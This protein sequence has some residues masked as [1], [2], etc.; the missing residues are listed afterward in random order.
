ME[1]LVWLG[2]GSMRVE[3]HDVPAPAHG[4]VLIRVGHAGICGSELEGYAGHS[5]IR[6]P[7]LVMG[8]EFAGH[9]EALGD[10]VTETLAIGDPVTV[11]PLTYC[12]DCYYCKAGRN[13]LCPT[14]TLI[15]AHRQGAFAGYVAV[16]AAT[17]VML[18]PGLGTSAGAL[19]EP[20]AVATRVAVLASVAS[21]DPVLVIGAGPI[22]LLTLQAFLLEGAGPVYVVDRNPARS[23]MAAAL[24]GI[25]LAAGE[26]LGREVRARCDDRGVAVAVDAVGSTTTRRA[27][28]EA[29][30]SGGRIIF[31][32][33]HEE[34]VTAP[35]V[36][37]IRREL[38]LQGV[39]AYGP[40]EF[41]TALSRI[42]AG[43]MHL[44]AWTQEAPLADGVAWFPRL[45][46]G[47][48]SVSKVLLQP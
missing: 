23:D 17:V 37:L 41:A 16:P 47:R 43:T 10:G 3:Q 7:P 31:S 19:C 36:E 24:G 30:R 5:A 26:N 15:G 14:R 33:L 28:I 29:T 40:T 32:G 46:D 42:A 18:P 2:P 1:A 25:P 6:L 20:A 8:H 4:E 44:G 12:G 48:V 27:C 11:N 38:T 22:G 34:A 45:I 9:V 39:Y 35:A 13:H 21:G